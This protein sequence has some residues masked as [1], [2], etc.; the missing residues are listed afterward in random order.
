M[1]NTLVTAFAEL[2]DGIEVMWCY[3]Y[4]I[5]FSI[6]NLLSHYHNLWPYAR[7]STLTAQPSADHEGTNYT[8]EC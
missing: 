3:N 2:N 5:H 7:N 1:C 6:M 4:F 8:C